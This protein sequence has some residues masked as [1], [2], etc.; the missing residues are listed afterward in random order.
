M[1]TNS[2]MSVPTVFDRTI[3]RLRSSFVKYSTPILIFVMLMLTFGGLWLPLEES[4]RELFLGLGTN[5]AS[6]VIILQL[7]FEK[8]Q[9]IREKDYDLDAELPKKEFIKRIESA[10]ECVRILDTYTYFAVHDFRD[11]VYRDFAKAIK[12]ALENGASVQILLH[13][14]GS[15]GA[16]RRAEALK[17]RDIDVAKLLDANLRI[18]HRLQEELCQADDPKVRKQASK[19]KVHLYD[20]LPELSLH[21]A[22]DVMYI[23]AFPPTDR[24]DRNEHIRMPIRDVS[25]GKFLSQNFERYWE[26][27]IPLDDYLL[28]ELIGIGDKTYHLYYVRLGG[29]FYATYDRE[30]DLFRNHD[31]LV[32]QQDFK[33]ENE[34][35]VREKGDY[36]QVNARFLRDTDGR[37]R[38][39]ALEELQ[40]RY[41]GDTERDKRPLIF[42]RNNPIL[43]LEICD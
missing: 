10:S 12:T 36:Y 14:P 42:N 32:L 16:K 3:N 23:S 39:L 4:Y 17:G 43:R 19:F 8:W 6:A 11:P 7:G 26:N 33:P 22:D 30:K 9:R 25:I 29:I 31:F 27:S 35:M 34:Y 2:S 24:A 15:P 21:L 20:E 38:E 1:A 18:L 41:A 37:E 40:K 13:R 28:L 5:L